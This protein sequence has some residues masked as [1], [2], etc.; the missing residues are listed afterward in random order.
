MHANP[1][2][3]NASTMAAILN[4]DS[5]L[6]DHA[7]NH[8]GINIKGFEAGS[9]VSLLTSCQNVTSWLKERSVLM[10]DDPFY[11]WLYQPCIGI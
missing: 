4:A 5:A 6:T 11:H 10:N 8:L 2:N 7:N 9:K 3:L 1:R